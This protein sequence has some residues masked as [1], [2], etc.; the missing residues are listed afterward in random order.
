[1]EEIQIKPIGLVNNSKTKPIDDNWS[2]I[3]SRIELMRIY[4]IFL[5]DSKLFCQYHSISKIP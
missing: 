3:D 1:M 4:Q 5:P 2:L